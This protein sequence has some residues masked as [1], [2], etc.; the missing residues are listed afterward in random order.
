MDRRRAISTLAVAAGACVLP[1]ISRAQ[2]SRIRRVGFVSGAQTPVFFEAFRSGLL[3]LGYVEGKSVLFHAR[4]GDGNNAHLIEVATALVSERPDVIVTQGAAIRPVSQ[5]AGDIPVVFGYSGD[6]V[7]AGMVKS[8]ARPGT[9]RTGISL[10]ALDLVG[11]RMELL[12]EAVPRLKSVAVLANPEHPGEEFE[13]RAAQSSA[14][15]LGL[16]HT[17]FPARSADEL[18]ATM[19]AIAKSGVEGLVVFPDGLTLANSRRIADSAIKMRAAAVA[20]WAQFT[21]NGFLM[22]YG[23]NLKASYRRLATF[24]DKI[25]KGADPASLP[26]E[27]PN[28]VEMVVNTRTAQALALEIPRSVL[29][30]ADRVES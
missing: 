9:K 14:D 19:A 6:P 10:L 22:S 3:D 23:P 21:E 15:A 4:F 20:G 2:A 7:A 18:D 30:R 16:Q 12:R 1:R 8:L 13:R 28:V 27:L 5:L 17:Y 26:I 24:V 25:L 29:L 11:K